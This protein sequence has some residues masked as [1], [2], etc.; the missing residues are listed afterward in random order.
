M[1]NKTEELCMAF[2]YWYILKY[3]LENLADLLTDCR[4]HA[5]L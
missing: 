4:H 2:I 3:I 1:V 5:L